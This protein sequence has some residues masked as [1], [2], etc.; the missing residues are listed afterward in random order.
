MSSYLWRIEPPPADRKLPEAS[1]KDREAA[2]PLAKPVQVLLVSPDDADREA[3]SQALEGTRWQVHHAHSC[4]E[5]I[6]MMES[7]RF[8]V[9]I[10]DHDCCDLGCVHAIRCR[11]V[12]SYPAPVIVAAR[13]SDFRLWEDVID[14][15]GLEILPKP[16]EPASVRKILE[17]AYKHWLAGDFRR[18]WERFDYPE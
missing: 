15:G 7:N 10:R 5:A 3:L 11:Q 17:F 1:S 9:I 8:P 12:G 18:R 16:F 13:A 4:V 14:R 6:P 2:S